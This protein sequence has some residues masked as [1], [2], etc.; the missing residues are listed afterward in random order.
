MT[1]HYKEA[2]QIRFGLYFNARFSQNLNCLVYG[3]FRFETVCN[4]N[5]N[6]LSD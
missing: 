2:H 5:K 4:L 6:V 1:A 3:R